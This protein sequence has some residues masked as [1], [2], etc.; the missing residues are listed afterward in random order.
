MSY[1]SAERVGGNL[2]L[3][4]NER[5]QSQMAAGA[6]VQLYDILEKAKLCR[7]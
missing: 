7:Q 5:S 2:N 4:L 3:L 1:Q 6:R